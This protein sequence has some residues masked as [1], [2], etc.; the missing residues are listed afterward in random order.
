MCQLYI[1]LAPYMEARTSGLAALPSWEVWRHTS[2]GGQGAISRAVSV[3][4]TAATE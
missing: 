4:T 3:Q 1:P 2:L